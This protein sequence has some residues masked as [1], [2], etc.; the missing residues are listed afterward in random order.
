MK[1]PKSPKQNQSS[2][3]KSTLKLL[4]EAA[5]LLDQDAD[6]LLKCHTD[7]R[8]EWP[9]TS[10]EFKREYNQRQLFARELRK[11]AGME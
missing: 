2:L 6:I 9:R 7:S 4:N 10:A 11:F 5:Q 1:S 8:G 3:P